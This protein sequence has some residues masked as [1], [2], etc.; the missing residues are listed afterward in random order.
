MRTLF[1]LL[2]QLAAAAAASITIKEGIAGQV[3]FVQPLPFSSKS[4]SYTVSVDPSS[5]ELQEGC[6]ASQILLSPLYI[7][8]S[9]LNPIDNN[10]SGCPSSTGT[11]ISG[12][13]NSAGTQ[14]PLNST[15]P[16]CNQIFSEGPASSI[17]SLAGA[18]TYARGTVTCGPS[19]TGYLY[20]Q[21]NCPALPGTNESVFIIK[22][23]YTVTYP[24]CSSNSNSYY[25]PYYRNSSW[26]SWPIVLV[27]FIAVFA[28]VFILLTVCRKRKRQQQLQTQQ[29]HMGH[30]QM[31]P[32]PPP[33]SGGIV[34]GAPYTGGSPAGYPP[35][36]GPSSMNFVPPPSGISSAYPSHPTGVMPQPSGGG[37]GSSQYP[38]PEG[39]TQPGIWYAGGKPPS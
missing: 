30:V 32:P 26:A 11:V 19:S 21:N 12:T 9:C 17:L 35:P 27:V 14:V 37:G 31:M 23:D 36:Q 25:D 1:L 15:T 4:F 29:Q 2:L 38:T 8:G 3:C 28:V 34:M 10:N 13:T 5:I 6:D 33:G 22:V 24:S 20:F 7:S 16:L 18:T 39:V